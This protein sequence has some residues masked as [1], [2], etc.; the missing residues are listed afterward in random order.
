MPGSRRHSAVPDLH[1]CDLAV[2]GDG[3]LGL[4]IALAMRARHPDA[5]IL[6]IAPAGRAGG[7]TPA[8]AAMLTAFAEIEPDTLHHPGRAAKFELARRSVPRWTE[9][10]A[11]HAERAGMAAPPITPGTVVT[12][13]DPAVDGPTLDAIRDAADHHGVATESLELRDVPGLRPRRTPPEAPALRIA[14]EGAIDP[15]EVL[16]VLDAAVEESD[17]DRLCDTAI[18]LDEQVVTLATGGTIRADRVVVANGA[19]ASRLLDTHVDLVGRVPRV[20]FGTGVGIRATLPLDVDLPREVVR[21]PNRP[22]GHGVYF[23]PHGDGRFYVGATCDVGDE[24]RDLPRVAS[25]RRILDAA[26]DD[27]SA[28]IGAAECH[29][30]LGHRPVSADGLP[31]IGRASGSIWIVTGTHRDGLVSAPEI[32]DLVAD[33]ITTGTAAVPTSLQPCRLPRDETVS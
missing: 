31:I 25:L 30:V 2:V 21:T 29:A 32:A 8:A 6:V 10:I 24:P 14:G 17:I 13:T 11:A 15:V 26:M 16:A 4:A 22:D 3:V 7:A 33:E 20:R 28:T 19:H 27:L 23:A 5:R 1:E 9:W 12:V 18:G